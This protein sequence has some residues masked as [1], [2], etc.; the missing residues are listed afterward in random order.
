[1]VR[2]IKGLYSRDEGQYK[3]FPGRGIRDYMT[4]RVISD[5]IGDGFTK[6][7]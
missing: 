1:M 6:D 5:F 4:V 7:T 3:Y 2:V